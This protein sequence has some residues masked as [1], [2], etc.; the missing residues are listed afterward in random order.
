LGKALSVL[1]APIPET[2]RTFGARRRIRLADLDPHGRVRLDAVARLLQDI[3]IDDVD[4]TG[5]GAPEHLWFVRTMR[6]D[7]LRPLVGDRTVE[8]VTWCSGVGTLA[9]GRR[10]SVTGDAGGRIEVDSVWIH[11]DQTGVPA[12]I[13]EFG[14][15]A[16]AAG[17]RR[18]STRAALPAPRAVHRL[19]WP[20]RATD[21]DLH[22][23]VN[24]AVYWQG[25]EHLLVENGPDV[26]MPLRARIE[27]RE[28]IDLEEKVELAVDS[29]PGRLEVAFLVAGR[30][31]AVALAES[32]A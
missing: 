2:G 7:V 4:E 24:N 18:V 6:L 1:L 32:L 5:W 23:H 19:P 26:R 20:L 12:R 10:W 27:Y 15:Y 3:A 16:G 28:P 8:L 22:G 13:E 17:G 21:I 25:V 9:A 31:K 29:P 11:L 14:V 30:T